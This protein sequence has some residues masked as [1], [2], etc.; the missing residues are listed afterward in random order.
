MTE[1][2]EK[3]IKTLEEKIE[4]LEKKVSEID[5]RTFGS[6]RFGGALM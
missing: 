3:R 4:K 5:S 1:K 6:R 2:L